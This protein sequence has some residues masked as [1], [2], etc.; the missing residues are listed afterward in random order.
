M[1]RKNSQ[2]F[3]K[4]TD[5]LRL[6]GQ[7]FSFTTLA[8][9]LLCEHNVEQEFVCGP[10]NYLTT[11]T[12]N[13]ITAAELNF[14]DQINLVNLDHIRIKYFKKFYRAMRKISYGSCVHLCDKWFPIAQLI[15]AWLHFEI[16]ELLHIRP[17]WK[18]FW[19][20]HL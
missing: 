4:R 11:I 3:F 1:K 10:I 13:G 8:T 9:S 12:K 17:P 16:L 7:I 14:H 5:P 20:W 18:F 15:L 6:Q 19:K 2:S